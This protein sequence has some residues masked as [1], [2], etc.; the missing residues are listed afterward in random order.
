MFS[1]GMQ[2]D[3]ARTQNDYEQQINNGLP[4]ES[5][6]EPSTTEEQE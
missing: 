2:S 1:D 5:G 3:W 4:L 6:R